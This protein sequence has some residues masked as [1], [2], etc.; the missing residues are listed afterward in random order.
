MLPDYTFDSFEK[1]SLDTVKGKYLHR[2]LVWNI[3]IEHYVNFPDIET[4]CT[5]KLL[6]QFA[7]TFGGVIYLAE[8]GTFKAASFDTLLTTLAYCG[9]NTR[10]KRRAAKQ[11]NLDKEVY[12]KY[13]KLFGW[14]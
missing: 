11:A 2:P 6:D 13:P 3:N 12:M 1:L 4:V 9:A 14:I 10:D 8:S 5:R 7:L